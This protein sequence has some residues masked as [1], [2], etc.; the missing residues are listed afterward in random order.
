LIRYLYFQFVS[1]V[2]F[3][4]ILG[5]TIHADA[6]V[7]WANGKSS[8][9][10]L[11]VSIITY[12]RSEE[13]ASW[14]GHTSI[15]V[16]DKKYKIGRVYNY[17]MFHFGPD[18]LPK[19]LTGEMRFW[20]GE[21]SVQGTFRLYES[22]NRDISIQVLNIS[23]KKRE[24]IAKYMADYV[25]PENRYYIYDHYFDNCSTRPRDV[26]DLATGGQFKKY[27]MQKSKFTLRDH[28]Q[29]YAQH[30][31][32]IYFLLTAWMNIEIDQPLTLWEDM[33]LPGE[34]E[35][36]L[37]NF[38]YIDEKGVEKPIVLKTYSVYKSNRSPPP[39]EPNLFWIRTLLAGF[40]LGLFG[41]FLRRRI[42]DTFTKKERVPYAFFVILFGLL[43]GIPSL[44]SMGFNFTHHTITHWNENLF[45]MNL[46][47][48]LSLPFGFMILFG[49]QKALSWLDKVWV[50]LTVTSLILV[51]LKI[52]PWFGQQN[53]Q[54]I[55]FYLPFYA[56][57]ALGTM[58][59][60]VG[61]RRFAP[62]TPTYGQ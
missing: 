55:A 60:H 28:T 19:F 33:F 46:F 14:F 39:A 56:L 23:P 58:S 11:E 6:S 44:A 59:E 30:S 29:R 40:I 35:K 5:S 36:N 21:A 15:L 12:S 49:S 22:L 27:A 62:S 8:G 18:L 47:T 26:V 54:V 24:E 32:Y 20:V 4:T 16:Q 10:D 9:E 1:L 17:G 7:P 13:I 43:L 31:P 34:L 25:L 61:F 48:F 2:V 37:N 38:R 52:T 51:V 45:M 41:F 53:G 42:S 57:L 50:I 3:F